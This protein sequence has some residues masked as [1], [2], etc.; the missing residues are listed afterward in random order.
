MKKKLSIILFFLIIFSI[1]PQDKND[2]SKTDIPVEKNNISV[3]EEINL[4]KN[5]TGEN[6]AGIY[7]TDISNKKDAI[8]FIDGFWDATFF[9]FGQFEFFKDHAQVKSIQP[10]FKQKANLSLWL[11]AKQ[12]FY[13][14]ALYKDD[15]KR[16]V[17]ALGY[18]GKDSS[19]IRHIRLGNSGI[20][21][22]LNYGYINTGGGKIIAPG[23]MATFSGKNWRA[24]SIIRYESAKYNSRIYYGKN[25]LQENNIAINDWIKSQFFYIPYDN[26]H[27]APIKVFVKEFNTSNWKELAASDF[28]INAT[29]KVLVLNKPY[30]NGVAINYSSSE[31]TNIDTFLNKV[32]NSFPTTHSQYTEIKTNADLYKEHVLYKDCLTLK[33]ENKFSPFE[34]CSFYKFTDYK[35]STSI[36]V[37]DNTTDSISNDFITSTNTILQTPNNKKYI[38]I[39]YDGSDSEE[40]IKFL[41][42]FIKTDATNIY[43]TKKIKPED[44]AFKISSETYTPRSE[45]ILPQDTIPGSIKVFKNKIEIKNFKYDENTNV[46]KLEDKILNTDYI[47]IK[48]QEGEVYSDSGKVRI[49][50]GV[51]W[52]ALKELDIFFANSSDFSLSK[53]KIDLSDDHEFSSGIEFSKYNIK[54]GTNIGFELQGLRNKQAPPKTYLQNYIFKND[55]YFD[56]TLNKNIYEINGTP[57][58]SNPHFHIDNKIKSDSLK[59][60]FTLNSQ[61]DASLDIWKINLNGLLSLSNKK[62]NVIKSYAHNI[63]IPIFFFGMT[64]NFFINTHDKILSRE[65]NIYFNKYVDANYSTYIS[66]NKKNAEQKIKTSISPIIPETKL[67]IIF[68]QLDF[69]ITQT[70]PIKENL[71]YSHYSKIWT[72]SLIDTYSSG[73][74]NAKKRNTQ[75]RFIFNIFTNTQENTEEDEKTVEF[76]GANINAYTKTNFK[77]DKMKSAEETTLLNMSFPFKVKDVFLTPVYTRRII[78]N[79]PAIELK[80]Q[81]NYARDLN[82]LWSG[83]QTQFWIFTK[84]ILYDLFDKNINKQMQINDYNEYSFYNNYSFSISRLISTSMMDLFLPIEFKAGISR[85]TKSEK[86]YIDASDIYGLE[87]QAKYIAVNISGKY[88]FTNWLSGYEQDELQR[89]YKYNFYFGNNFFKFNLDTK[90]SLLFFLNHKNKMEFKNE[91]KCSTLKTENEKINLESWNEKFSFSFMSSAKNTLP[92]LI[93]HSFSEVDIKN[94]REEKVSLQFFQNEKSSKLNYQLAFSHSQISKITKHGEIRLFANINGKSTNNNSFLFEF[95]CGLSGKIEY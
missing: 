93:I 17:L 56:Y 40:I 45:I 30:P 11:L 34:I 69:N 84:P 32:K 31:K 6:K 20:K 33:K 87:F 95:E 43:G 74:E 36:N 50:N 94:F 73:E 4:I 82:S 66:Y 53:Q 54:T 47:E 16:S 27:G 64:E 81:D 70:F 1:F 24:D 58:F 77:N 85:E 44:L 78:R 41:F 28:R 23:V 19:P 46:L 3:D 12:Q 15:Y 86:A 9:G 29:Q 49:A 90:H 2:E 38:K 79:K 80:H 91:F 92:D 60:T 75:L 37:I 13:F 68:T 35:D 14:E 65:N 67:G 71:P 5:R 18:F 59:K 72:K 26:L 39:I 83:M 76:L 21:F 10:I 42:P 48:W 8:L 7:F 63:N 57:I 51:H 25:E 55:V 62:D 52:Q 61:M 89:L 88:G 22:P